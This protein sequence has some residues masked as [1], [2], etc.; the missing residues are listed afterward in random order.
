MPDAPTRLITA[1]GLRDGATVKSVRCEVQVNG[2]PQLTRLLEPGG[3]WSPVDLDLAPWRGQPVLL[4]FV[5]EAEDN[6]RSSQ[7]LWAEPRLAN[8]GK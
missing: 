8:A 6:A 1:I 2:E 3:G 7:A 4:T 5:T